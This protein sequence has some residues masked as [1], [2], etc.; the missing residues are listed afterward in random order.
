[1]I[2]LFFIST[3][4]FIKLSLLNQKYNKPQ[5]ALVVQVKDYTIVL[6]T[7]VEKF[8]LKIRQNPFQSLFLFIVP[9]A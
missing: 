9:F 4:Y 3:L 8:E 7:E 6:L 1:M 5:F 2:F